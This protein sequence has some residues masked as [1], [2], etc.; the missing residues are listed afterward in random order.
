MENEAAA[1]DVVYEVLMGLVKSK[2]DDNWRMFLKEALSECIAQ[3]E[4]EKND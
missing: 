4:R 2:D 3:H 1:T